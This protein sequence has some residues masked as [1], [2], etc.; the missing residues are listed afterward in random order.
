[1]STVEY[2]GIGKPTKVC[3]RNFLDGSRAISN[4]GSHPISLMGATGASATMFTGFVPLRQ[5]WLSW[6]GTN[7]L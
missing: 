6:V 7:R 4:L 5:A 3:L 1:M 2:V